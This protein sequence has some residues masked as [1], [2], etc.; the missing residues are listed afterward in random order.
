M[1]RPWLALDGTPLLT[2]ARETRWAWE[3]FIEEGRLAAVRPQVAD[4]WQRSRAAGIDP[5]GARNAPVL[6]GSDEIEARWEEHPLAAAA[7]PLVRECLAGVAA[8]SDHLIVVTDADGMLLWINGNARV[9]MD[10]ADSMNFAEGTLWSERA[11]GTNA[12]GT[13]IAADHAVQISP[14][15][16]S[17]RSPSAGH[18][19]PRPSTTPT[20]GA[21]SESSISADRHGRLIHIAWPSPRRPR[22]PSR[23]SSAW[24]F[25]SATPGCAHD[26][27]SASR[28]PP[29]TARS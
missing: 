6:A 21:C 13:A 22:A 7:A 25:A 1:R 18:A 11:A 28:R 10:A 12:I 23:R 3:E 29:V 14:P 9:R 27:R 15:S 5:F 4:S 17:T 26:M 20:T 24:R 2:R 16:T 8:E 19:R